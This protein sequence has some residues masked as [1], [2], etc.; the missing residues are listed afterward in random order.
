[1]SPTKAT[2]QR[3]PKTRQK[4]CPQRRDVDYN[5][6]RFISSRCSQAFERIEE[7]EYLSCREPTAHNPHQQIETEAADPRGLLQS[8]LAHRA[9]ERSTRLR[10]CR[11]RT[12]DPM[13]RPTTRLPRLRTSGISSAAVRMGGTST[14]GSKLSAN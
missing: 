9:R 14:I 12:T 11:V 4:K 10:I 1:M 7:Q 5:V 6:S 2:S 13:T 8:R 3:R